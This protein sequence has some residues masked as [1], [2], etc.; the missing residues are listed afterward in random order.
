MKL[1][2]LTRFTLT[3][4][5]LCLASAL[6]CSVNAHTKSEKVTV[7]MASDSPKTVSNNDKL[8]RLANAMS[9]QASASRDARNNVDTY[10]RSM[11]T[12][13]SA[14]NTARNN[15]ADAVHYSS[16]ENVRL[17]KDLARQAPLSM[18]NVGMET[19]SPIVATAVNNTLAF[20]Q[21]QRTNILLAALVAKQQETRRKV[22]IPFSTGK[23]AL[24][25][26]AENGKKIPFF[27]FVYDFHAQNYVQQCM[28]PLVRHG[29]VTLHQ[30]H[31][32][33]DIFRVLASHGDDNSLLHLHHCSSRSEKLNR[34]FYDANVYA[35]HAAA[36]LTAANHLVPTEHNNADKTSVIASPLA[37]LREARTNVYT[38]SASQKILKQSVG[39]LETQKGKSVDNH[40]LMHWQKLANRYLDPT[41]VTNK[42]PT[43]S[44]SQIHY[45]DPI[46][47]YHYLGMVTKNFSIDKKKLHRTLSNLTPLI[48][49]DGND[50]NQI[51]FV[52]SLLN[53]EKNS[54]TLV[55][56]GGNLKALVQHFNRPVFFAHKQAVMFFSITAVP[57]LIVRSHDETKIAVHVFAMPHKS[58]ETTK[59]TWMVDPNVNTAGAF[60]KTNRQIVL[61]AIAA[62]KI[63]S[64][65]TSDCNFKKLFTS[66]ALAPAFPTDFDKGLNAATKD[67]HDDASAL[68][69]AANHLV[70]TEHNNADTYSSGC[71]G[72]NL[73]NDGINLLH[74]DDIKPLPFS[75]LTRIAKEVMNTRF[76]TDGTARRLVGHLWS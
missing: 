55:A 16:C 64:G 30:L 67:M 70:P 75:D 57:A 36:L 9:V 28:I 6:F 38:L 4:S 62:K 68:L 34:R 47:R 71:G 40:L 13:T 24:Y 59:S 26:Y 27:Q 42:I 66:V 74:P 17:V 63:I 10:I 14:L 60:Y 1:N 44:Q 37:R 41:L 7:L 73:S 48:Y 69:R 5:T 2:N 49:F 20:Y 11:Q 23:N 25:L 43:A 39:Q 35:V 33:T 29:S 32:T 76:K 46:R 52:D 18:F 61:S 54:V 56:T 65:S 22:T 12:K 51:A 45:I 21:R 15:L 19:V 31:S 3:L 72:I 8:D 58:I 50:P 53:N